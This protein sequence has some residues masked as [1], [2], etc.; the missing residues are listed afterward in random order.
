MIRG[1]FIPEDGCKWGSFDYS[2]QEPRLLVHFAAS[3]NDDHRHQMVDGIVNEWQTKDIDLHQMVADIAGIDRKS[4]KTVNLG[5]MYGMGKA[6]LADQLDISV[7]EATTLL[8]T[9]QSKVPFVKG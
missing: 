5:I 3:L 2:S 6:K 7:A 9:H 8:Q 4:A 1:L